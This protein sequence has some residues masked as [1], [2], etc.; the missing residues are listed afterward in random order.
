MD[1]R[2]KETK[3]AQKYE[4][5]TMNETVSKINLS[6]NGAGG[7]DELSNKC[8][9][10]MKA[11]VQSLAAQ[12]VQNIREIKCPLDTSEH[13]IHEHMGAMFAC[14]KY[15]QDLASIACNVEGLTSP[16]PKWG[17]MVS[18]LLGRKNSFS[19]RVWLLESWPCSMEGLIKWTAQIGVKWDY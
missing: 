2:V 4:E 13:C 9:A 18:W 11:Q 12:W 7:I 15:A 6:L 5:M 8:I 10:W 17:A 14:I 16:N 19:F 3:H 1:Y